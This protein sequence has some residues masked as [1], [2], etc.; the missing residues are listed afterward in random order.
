MSDQILYSLQIA[1]LAGTADMTSAIDYGLGKHLTEIPSENYAALRIRGLTSVALDAAAQ[2]F[3]KTS[4]AIMMLR[5]TEGKLR[6]FIWFILVS[7]NVFIGLGCLLFFVHCSPLEKVWVSEDPGTCFD[8]S[9]AVN[10][11]IFSSGEPSW[12]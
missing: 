5:I 7:M 9:I 2:G 6:I 4:F 1:L 3:S 11:G 10:F 12:L 8:F